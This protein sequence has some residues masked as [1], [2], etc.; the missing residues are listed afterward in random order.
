MPGANGVRMSGHISGEN[1]NQNIPTPQFHQVALGGVT[2]WHW[3]VAL[4]GQCLAAALHRTRGANSTPIFR[5][6]EALPG[7]SSCEF[8]AKTIETRCY[9]RGRR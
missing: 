5:L 9:E 8:C 2:R 4:G 6:K 1:Y 7:I 3:G